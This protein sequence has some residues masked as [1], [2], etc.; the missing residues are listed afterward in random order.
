[1]TAINWKQFLFVPAMIALVAG[2]CKVD[3]NTLSTD[4]LLKKEML[5]ADTVKITVDKNTQLMITSLKLGV[6]YMK[7]NLDSWGDGPSITR[8]INLLKNAV[9]YNNQHIFGFGADSP[10]PRPGIFDWSSLD[11]RVNMMITTMNS[12]PV[13]TFA[14][15]PTWMTDSTWY[16][17][18]YP[19]NDTDWDKVEWAPLP[20]KEKDFAHLCAL[21]AKRY[22]NVKYFQVWNELKSMWHDA[23]NHWDYVRYTRLYNLVYDSVKNVRPDAIIGGPYIGIDSWINPPSGAASSY[24]DPA[25]GTLDQRCL[26]VV[27]YWLANKH[28]A[29]FM[30]VD[31]GIDANDVDATDI[32]KATKKFKDVST[33]LH[34]QTTLP[35]WWSE[36]YVGMNTDTTIQPAALG[37]MI[38][39]HALGGD[40]VSLR[41]APE[42]QQGDGNVSNFFSSTLVPNGGKP[43]NNYYVYRDFNTYFPAGTKLCTTT[44]S[45]TNVMVVSSKTKIM[46]INRTASLQRT[47]I[48][49][50]LAVNLNPYQV[51]YVTLP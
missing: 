12:T 37:C 13:I 38:A 49:N 3:P 34:A 17:G 23:G 14:T 32:I 33:W 21:A 22:P 25:Y 2:S 31:G 47:K 9:V 6:T 15:A 29:D 39:Y 45:S 50:T 48:N 20:S 40:A 28:G 19:E 5:L 30:C 51:K 16:P 43:F 46:L 44:V 10:E 8:G 36:D 1:M 35:I 41:W 4:A 24:S 26:D 42:Q 7:N 18:K 11:T 27:T